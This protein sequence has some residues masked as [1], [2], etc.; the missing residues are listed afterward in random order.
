MLPTQAWAS[1]TGPQGCFV[2]RWNVHVEC[3]LRL[4]PIRT[5]CTRPIHEVPTY[6]HRPNSH[7]PHG[8]CTIM[9]PPYTL[10]INILSIFLHPGTAMHVPNPVTSPHLDAVAHLH[11]WPDHAAFGPAHL[12][13]P[14]QHLGQFGPPLA[15]K[16]ILPVGWCTH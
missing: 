11:L 14:F 8:W 13:L 1:H 15:P 4:H 9:C 5:M 16:A 10:S 3:C 6:A 7:F 12:S 2:H